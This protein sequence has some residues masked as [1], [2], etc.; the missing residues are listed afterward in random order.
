M[1]VA[2]RHLVECLSLEAL[3]TLKVEKCLIC[4]LDTDHRQE[5]LSCTSTPPC[6]HGILLMCLSMVAYWLRHHATRRKVAGSILDE[7]I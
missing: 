1:F 3:L 6:L 5:G 7:V 4:L 2:M